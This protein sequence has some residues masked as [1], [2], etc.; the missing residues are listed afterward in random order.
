MRGRTALCLIGHLRDWD[1]VWPSLKENVIDPL[2]PDIFGFTW[3]DSL[4]FHMHVHD[5]SHPSFSIGYDP[6]SPAI[7]PD[8]IDRIHDRLKPKVLQIMDPAEVKDFLDETTI[9]HRDCEPD[10]I[11]HRAR[12][13]FQMAYTKMA[14]IKLKRQYEK[15]NNLIYDRVIFTRWDWH[16]AEPLTKYIDM[17]PNDK[18]LIPNKYT[19]GGDCDMWA[20]GP[21]HLMDMYANILPTLDMVKT[22]PGFHTNPHHWMRWHFQYYDIP[23]IVA[24]LNMGIWNRPE[25]KPA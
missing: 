4:G 22:I 15:E 6:N 25:A 7:P 1:A 16:H 23:Y 12:P 2:Q 11:F 17:Y 9:R 21:S 19:Y 5:R 10:W 18:V 8:L 14:G 3:S 13:K 24:D 20:M